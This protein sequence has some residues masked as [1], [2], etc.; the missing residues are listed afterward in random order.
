MFVSGL[1]GHSRQ[2]LGLLAGVSLLWGCWHKL[3]LV[4]SVWG[5]VCPL[6]ISCE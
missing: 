4:Y 1:L 3:V 6:W 2:L 5:V